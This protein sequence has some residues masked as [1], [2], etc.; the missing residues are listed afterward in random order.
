M[1]G[2]NACSSR[3]LSQL[4]FWLIVGNFLILTWIG[5]QPVEYPYIVLGQLASVFYFVG[6]LLLR[7]GVRLIEKKVR[8]S[9]CLE[10]LLAVY[11]VSRKRSVKFRFKA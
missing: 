5:R 9:Y 10:S 1:S 6:F 8:E 3:P 4:V 2:Q 11:F 7:P